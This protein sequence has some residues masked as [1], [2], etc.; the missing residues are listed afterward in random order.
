MELQLIM[1]AIAT[2]INKSE[3]LQKTVTRR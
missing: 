2:I 3:V 1:I